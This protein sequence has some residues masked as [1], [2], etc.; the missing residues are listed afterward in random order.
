MKGSF[1]E[2]QKSSMSSGST[3]SQGPSSELGPPPSQGYYSQADRYD[4]DR[5]KQNPASNPKNICL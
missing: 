3:G 4:E 1:E 2:A 5:C